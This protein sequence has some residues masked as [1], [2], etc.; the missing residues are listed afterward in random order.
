MVLG[1]LQ[2]DVDHQH[3]QLCEGQASQEH[4]SINVV[5]PGL[6]GVEVEE[7]AG[8]PDDPDKEDNEVKDKTRHKFWLVTVQGGGDG[9]G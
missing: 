7:Q 9:G 1:H 3:Q 2:R 6:G 4:P 8:V 5:P